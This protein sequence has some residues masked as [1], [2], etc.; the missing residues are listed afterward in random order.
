MKKTL[1]LSVA[2]LIIGAVLFVGLKSKSEDV[3]GGGSE[4]LVLKVI[5]G[6]TI[7]V[8]KLGKVRYIGIDTPETKHPSRGPE[9]YGREAYEANK[10]LVEGKTIRVELDVAERDKYGRILA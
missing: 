6:D 10:R 4:Y 2:L 3:I 7:E 9:P 1:L 8:E 5:D